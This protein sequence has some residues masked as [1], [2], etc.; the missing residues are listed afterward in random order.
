MTSLG[1]DADTFFDNLL[2]G[3][4]GIGPIEQFDSELTA[5]KIAGEVRDFDVGDYWLPKDAKR[6][7]RYSHLGMAAAKNAMKDGGLDADIVDGKRFGVL[8]GTGVGGLGAVEKSCRILF[9]KGPKRIT[10]FLL[11]SIIGN[12]GGSLVAIELGAKGPNYGIVSSCNSGARPSVLVSTHQYSSSTH[13][14]SP[15]LTTPH[16]VMLAQARTR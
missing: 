7:D 16:L 10:P 4:C 12:M 11:P 5:V 8:I 6:Y 1:H 3:K 9:E 14:H 15:P 13:R 2:D